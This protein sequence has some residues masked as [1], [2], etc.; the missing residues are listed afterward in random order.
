M[1]PFLDD[2]DNVGDG[3]S[4]QKYPLGQ[5]A[6]IHKMRSVGVNANVR[7]LRSHSLA[8]AIDNSAPHCDIHNEH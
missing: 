3:G 7:L 5:R 2:A 8:T 1:E 4:G 6:T